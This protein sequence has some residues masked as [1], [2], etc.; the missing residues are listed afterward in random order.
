[1]DKH[2]GDVKEEAE[3]GNVSSRKADPQGDPMSVWSEEGR[4]YLIKPCRDCERHVEP[5]LGKSR[6]C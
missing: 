1:M 6:L 4:V 5:L 3:K 2:K